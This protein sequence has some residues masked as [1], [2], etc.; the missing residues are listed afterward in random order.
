MDKILNLRISDE[1]LKALEESKWVLRKSMGAITREALLEYMKQ[2][3]PKDSLRKINRM[4]NEAPE[5]KTK[6]VS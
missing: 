3:L 5:R 2:N 4:L 1:L 6:G